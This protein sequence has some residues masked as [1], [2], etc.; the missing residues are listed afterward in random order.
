MGRLLDRAQPQKG[1]AGRMRSSITSQHELSQ[2]GG[3][4]D[5]CPPAA[6]RVTL[7]S[8]DAC[9]GTAPK[10]SSGF[11]SRTPDPNPR[12]RATE[13]RFRKRATSETREKRADERD[14][15]EREKAEG[16]TER[17][18]ERPDIRVAGSRDE[19][20]G[21]KNGNV[22]HAPSPKSPNRAREFQPMK[23]ATA[24]IVTNDEPP[25]PGRSPLQ[26]IT[27][28]RSVCGLFSLRL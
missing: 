10:I 28:L 17:D 1:S 11:V 19:E 12:F 22:R 5:R 24:S 25:A 23:L 3:E 14:K 27:R 2:P 7:C 6:P 13:S 4:R 21:Q 15:A 9:Q 16:D 8:L 20:R 26:I 18:E